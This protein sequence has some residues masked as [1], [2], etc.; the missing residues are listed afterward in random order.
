MKAV[1]STDQGGGLMLL[2]FANVCFHLNK[3][4]MLGRAALS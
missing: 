4:H 1:S 2:T 3:R